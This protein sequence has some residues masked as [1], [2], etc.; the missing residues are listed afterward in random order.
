MLIIIY[1]I[2]NKSVWADDKLFE[3]V[4]DNEND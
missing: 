3:F 1:F 2:G 4:E